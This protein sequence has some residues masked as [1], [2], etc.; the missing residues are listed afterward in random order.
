MIRPEDVWQALDS[1]ALE[2]GLR[3]LALHAPPDWMPQPLIRHV[4]LGPMGQCAGP[5]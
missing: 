1:L 5:R 3:L 4:G 2:R